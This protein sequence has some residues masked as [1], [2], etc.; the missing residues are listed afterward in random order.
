[1]RSSWV[2]RT[3]DGDRLSAL[4]A[5]QRLGPAA[6]FATT[7]HF[8]LQT[9]RSMTVAEANGRASIYL[10]AVSSN[11]IALAFIGQVSR[12]GATFYAFGLILLPALAFV[13]MVTFLRLVQSSI[14]DIAFAQRIGRLRAFYIA[15]A[16]E[17]E[18]YVLVMRGDRM[19]SAHRSMR[20]VPS[21]WQLALTTA[22]MIGVVNSV[23]IAGGAGLLLRAL[24]VASLPI[25][26]GF[27]ASVGSGAL[28]LHHRHH[29][30]AR[31]TYRPEAVDEAAIYV[32]AAPQ[33]KAA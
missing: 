26:L 2:V 30:R 7:E 15:L 3:D 4:I 29:R 9:A 32:P 27:G 1:M 16:P 25:I 10:A 31:D 6:T 24:G 19:G 8:N 13:G 11:L 21:S 33:F 14:E 23:V 17:L 28:W 12:L 18:P 5:T 22:G 20:L